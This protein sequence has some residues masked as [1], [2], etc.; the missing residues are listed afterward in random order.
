M[1]EAKGDGKI[2]LRCPGCGR[3]VKFPAGM[4]G[5]TYRCPICH[6]TIV[7]PLSDERVEMPSE[8]EMRSFAHAPLPK[9]KTPDVEAG[10][11]PPRAVYESTSR[12]A[13]WGK[14]PVERL[15]DFMIRQT[16]RSTQISREIL[17]N[18]A[19]S[20]EKRRDKLLELRKA[21]AMRLRQFVQGLLKELDEQIG[22]TQGSARSETATG[23][24]QLSQLR[25]ERDQFK[26]YLEVMFQLQKASPG[27]AEQGTPDSAAEPPSTP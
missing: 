27:G 8:R 13:V 1:G 24:R 5:E 4:P 14:H 7:S 20:E 2:R 12:K 15:G 11:P 22:V 26:T 16:Q 17:A 18:E 10:P 3:R 21:K 23:K 6:T 19:W 9:E 25:H